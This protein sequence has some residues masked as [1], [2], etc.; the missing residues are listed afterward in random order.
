MPQHYGYDVFIAHADADL[1][2][3][4]NELLFSTWKQEVYASASAFETSNLVHHVSGNMN[5]L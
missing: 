5:G 4:Q 2:W 1:P 3:V